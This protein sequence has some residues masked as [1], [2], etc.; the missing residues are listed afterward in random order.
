MKKTLTCIY[1]GQKNKDFDYRDFNLI[2]KLKRLFLKHHKQCENDCNGVGFVKC[3]LYY[4]G[5][6]DDC[7]KNLYGL[8]V[9]SGW[10]NDTKTV[11]YAE[12]D[13]LE[14]KINKLVYQCNHEKYGLW[15]VKPYK[16]EFQHDPRGLTVKLYYNGNLIDWSLF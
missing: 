14:G 2:K 1:F 13:K 10:I 6:I 15:R 4:T 16:V 5:I 7:V 3:R 12:I 11:F 8:N 9:K